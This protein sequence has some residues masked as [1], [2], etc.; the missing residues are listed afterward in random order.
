[1]STI[2]RLWMPV[3]V[4]ALVGALGAVVLI[5]PLGAGEQAQA[6]VEPRTTVT[7]TITIPAAAFSPM[8]DN[9]DF[10]NN[11]ASLITVSG[12]GEF[13]A[14]IFFEAPEVIIRKLTLFAYDGGGADVCVKLLRIPPL[15]AD[16]ELMGE[17]C[18][19]GAAFGVRSFT[20]T[21]LSPRRITGGYGPALWLSLPGN[22][23]GW[24]FYGVRIIY[25]YETGG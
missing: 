10:F 1:M 22:S 24:A 6:V 4:A 17:A 18:S 5:G 15:T 3:L 9:T 14:P 23:S 2:R 19:T 12:S 11:S 13:I 21:S 16:G 7:R 20:Q 8:D 25:S